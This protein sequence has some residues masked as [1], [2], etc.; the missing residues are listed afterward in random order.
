MFTPAENGVPPTFSRFEIRPKADEALLRDVAI[1]P[2]H[3]VEP[4]LIDWNELESILPDAAHARTANISLSIKGD[5]LRF[6]FETSIPTSG[7]GLLQLSRGSEDSKIVPEQDI[8]SWPHFR[9]YAVGLTP[10][11]MVFRGQPVRRRLR[12]SFHRSGRSDLDRYIW[13]DIPSLQHAL[14]N[15]VPRFASLNSPQDSGAFYNLIQH[16][17]FPTPLLDWTYSPF[18]AAFFAF[19]DAAPERDEYVRIFIFDR[20]QWDEITGGPSGALAYTS[21]H[22]SFLDLPAVDNPRALPQQALATITNLEDMERFVQWHEAKAGKS[23]LRAVDLPASERGRALAELSVMG[24]TAG[25]LFPGI[26]GT[27]E[28]MRSRL[29]GYS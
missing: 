17:G 19:R 28:Q 9:E 20:E 23:I 4:R 7:D 10:F 21:A 29:F 6:G 16:H 15:Q 5:G 26:D 3:P 25:S 11:T 2:V 22:L 14:A 1:F 8:R 27:C 12:T 13:K 18:I 24:I